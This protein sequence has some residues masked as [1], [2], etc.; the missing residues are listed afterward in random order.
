MFYG[1]S[2]A[3][4]IQC[5]WIIKAISDFKLTLIGWGRIIHNK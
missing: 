2:I 3:G 1:K 5:D 4:S